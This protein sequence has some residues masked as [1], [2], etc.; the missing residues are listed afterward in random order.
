M[1]PRWSW[2]RTCVAVLGALAIAVVIGVPT[3]LIPSPFYVR[4]TPVPWWSYVTWGATAFLS[5]PLIAIYVR[6]PGRIP[7]ASGAGALANIGSVLAVGCPVCNKV[8]VAM[9][10]VSGALSV[11]APL[12]PIIAV[13]ALAL[14]GWALWLRIRP[15][16]VCPIA[17]DPPTEA[18]SRSATPDDRAVDPLTASTV[19]EPRAGSGRA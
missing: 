18:A 10:G 7:R 4:M 11:W 19:A 6:A 2:T 17:A 8:V 16:T 12:Q 15:E 9:L 13:T 14:L 5:G 3:G 1:T